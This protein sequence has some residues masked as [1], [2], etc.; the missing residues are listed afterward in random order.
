MKM[1]RVRRKK[2]RQIEK[3]RKIKECRKEGH[4]QRLEK[5]GER[6]IE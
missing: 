4:G 5:G 1:W 3:E 2:K 6:K